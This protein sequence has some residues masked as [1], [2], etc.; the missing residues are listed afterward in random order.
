MRNSLLY[1]AL[2]CSTALFFSLS[3][4]AQSD[5]PVIGD[6]SL[7]ITASVEAHLYHNALSQIDH[8][9]DLT[10]EKQGSINRILSLLY[11]RYPELTYEIEKAPRSEVQQP[12]I[13]QLIL[14]IVKQETTSGMGNTK[15]G[16]ASSLTKEQLDP[17]SLATLEFL[18]AYELFRAKRLNEADKLWQKLLKTRK[19]EYE[20]AAYY[21]GLTAL[22]QGRNQEAI[23]Y[24]TKVGKTDQ[25]R[26]HV[27]YYLA[28]AHFAT[29]DYASVIKYYGPRTSE[30]QLHNIAGITKI[31]GYSYYKSEDYNQCITALKKLDLYQDLNDEES[32]VLSMALSKTGQN[33]ESN[34]LLAS[35]AQSEGQIKVNA[36]YEYALQLSTQGRYQ[37]ALDKFEKMINNPAYNKADVTYNLALLNGKI[38][39]YDMVAHHSLQLQTTKYAPQANELLSEVLDNVENDNLYQRIALTLKDDANSKNILKTSL[40][41]RGIAALKQRDFNKANS[42]FEL[43]GKVDPLIEE[44]GAVAAWK[45]IMAFNNKDY[46]SAER[47]LSN[48]LGSKSNNDVASKLEFDANYF[49]AY[50]HFKLHQHKQ[51]LGYFSKAYTLFNESENVVT[52][53]DKQSIHEDLNLRLGDNYFLID[54]YKSA[55]AS[56]DNAVALNRDNR[57]YAL[58]QQAVIAELLNN[59]YDQILILDDI[60]SSHK[61]TKY[62][63]KAMFSSANT[64]FGLNKYDKAATF[65]QR[66]IAED[67]PQRMKEESTVQ[68]GLIAVNAGEYDRAANHYNDIV[69]NSADPEMKHRAQLALKEIYSDY[70][71]DT[72]AYIELVAQTSEASDNPLLD[73]ALYDL[74]MNTYETGVYPKAIEQWKKLIK[75]YP[76]S[77]LIEKSWL[78]IG[79]SEE[80]QKHYKEAITAYQAI[81]TGSTEISKEAN[82]RAIDLAYHE[83][84]DYNLYIQLRS[85]T[86]EET[87]SALAYQDAS[88]HLNT[89]NPVQA[90]PL[91]ETIYKSAEI[92]AKKKRVLLHDITQKLMLKKEWKAIA[93]LSAQSTIRSVIDAAPKHIYYRALAHTNLRAL[94]AASTAI[95][96][97][98]STLLEDPA[99]LA[100]SIILLSDIYVLQGNIEDAETALQALV[101]T[102]SQVPPSLI[103]VAKNR[104][105][106]LV[107]LSN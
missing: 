52:S 60:I 62:Y 100:K 31:V 66:I 99:W 7:D 29:E 4:Q 46:K 51:S 1:S 88:A 91:L 94:E 93:D 69:A 77:A 71:Y 14:A 61:S 30:T 56:Y 72:D 28:A 67:V 82:S 3:N 64:L 17:Q 39:K 73:Q 12:E 54:N 89:D 38:G 48:Y 45:G 32:Y 105:E 68:L 107:H 78:H 53:T 90:I 8:Y 6:R 15:D 5:D 40:Y 2:I 92:N 21:A 76:E 22:I 86:K 74:A 9:A 79:K 58:W 34:S 96:E 44:R 63:H 83:I 24:L 81:N 101:E 18:Y 84:K 70:T 55:Y 35:V 85:T 50:T 103:K 106:N 36:A 95:T 42:Y 80:A 23:A 87:T 97:H 65:Y 98:Y 16:L 37:E 27:P 75:D 47:L 26:P 19:G 20:Y 33:T 102:E 43:L 41:Q 25:L 11:T 57:P 104:L 49:L 10:E 59:P 13:A